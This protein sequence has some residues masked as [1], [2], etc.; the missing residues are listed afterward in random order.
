MPAAEGEGDDDQ[1]AAEG[2]DD[3]EA[4]PRSSGGA[5]ESVW[6]PTRRPTPR[7]RIC[8]RHVAAHPHL[9][10]GGGL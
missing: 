7:A 8:G 4:T 5:P 9:I 2:P 6:S 10:R 1:E 3:P